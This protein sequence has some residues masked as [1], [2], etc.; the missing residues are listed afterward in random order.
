MQALFIG[1]IGY[2]SAS[3]KRARV[4]GALR[5]FV[6]RTRPDEGGPCLT[7]SSRRCKG[8]RLPCSSPA[9]RPAAGASRR[10]GVVSGAALTTIPAGFTIIGNDLEI[11]VLEGL[12]PT[13][14]GVL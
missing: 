9:R 10:S 12:P 13:L 8:D 1:T 7:S 5:V 11:L 2:I 6:P 3:V 14:P 4:K